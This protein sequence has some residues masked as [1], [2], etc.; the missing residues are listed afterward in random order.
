MI[1]GESEQHIEQSTPADESFTDLGNGG[2]STGVVVPDVRIQSSAQEKERVF[3][4][5]EHE[6]ES[7]R[8]GELSRFQASSRV[9]IELDK[10]AEASDKDKGKALDSY[11]A[12]IN[13]FAAMQDENR[14]VTRETISLR[15]PDRAGQQPSRKRIREE[16]EELLDQVSGEELEGEGD[17]QRP[18]RRRAR[19][20]EMPWYN[21]TNNPSRRSSCVETCRTLLQFSEDLTGVKSLLRV[22]NNLPEGIPSSQWD[23]ILR[24]ESV[25][26]NQILSSMHF[27]QL[28][29]ERK[30][31]LGRAEVVFAVTESKRQV[32]SGS[33]WS[34]AFRRMSKAVTFLFPHRREELYEYAE[35]IEGLFS[36]KH[37]GA[38]SKVILYDQS[39]RN[40]VGG[41]QN[42]LLTNYQRFSSLSEA[43]LHADG[44]EYKGA[45]KG[46]SK[47]GANSDK[48]EPSKKDIC[49]RFNGQAGCRFSEEDCY[50]KHLCKGCGKG[51]HGKFSCP[52]E[53]HQ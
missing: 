39:I 44:I 47:G 12:E 25:D 20:E 1:H 3:E 23:R 32:K 26:L 22:A 52:A 35:Y 2:E 7:F 33:D 48:G 24:G 9:T 40:Q 50:Y 18:M 15:P 10:W 30:G 17:E 28:D 8:R 49:R 21:S 29:E 6:M 43:I 13:S 53:K 27:V 37:A 36:A 45:G 41:G 31:R 38:H 46:S 11:L 19:E 14:S 5:V 34:S 16:V 42:T 51:G 4:R